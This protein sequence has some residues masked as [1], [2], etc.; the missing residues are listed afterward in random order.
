MLE[1]GNT[2]T[3][4]YITTTRLLIITKL[5]INN[6][7]NLNNT[8]LVARAIIYLIVMWIIRPAL[9][10]NVLECDLTLCKIL[11]DYIKNTDN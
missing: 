10:S 9:C 3:H 6:I 1:K 5:N 7:V 2:C 4:Y 11:D 8:N